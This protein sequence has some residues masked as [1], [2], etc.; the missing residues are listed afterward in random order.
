[1]ERASESGSS[2]A[3]L[4][5]GLSVRMLSGRHGA[6][7]RPTARVAGLAALLGTLAMGLAMALMTGYRTALEERLLEGGASVLVFEVGTLVREGEVSDAEGVERA[8]LSLPGVLAVRRTGFLQGVV[9]GPRGER[10][11]T[12]RLGPPARGAMAREAHRLEPAIGTVPKA[13]LGEE[14]AA[15]LGVGPGARVQLALYLPDS[16]G[17]RF[18]YRSLEVAG[19]YLTGFSEFDTS[20]LVVDPA[21]FPVESATP[22]ARVWEVGVERAES[23]PAV[24]EALREKLGGSWLVTDWTQMNRQLFSALRL[25]Q[26]VLFLLLGLIVLVA[27]FAVGA[28]VAVLGRERR[29]DLALLEALGLERRRI[30]WILGGFA[31]GLTAVGAVSGLGLTYL[32]SELATRFEWLSFGPEVAEVYFLRSVPLRLDLPSAGAILAFTFA[33]ALLASAIPV[34]RLARLDPADALRGD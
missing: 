27:S 22:F 2:V 7:L 14:L 11:V 1:M 18:R 28:T 8:A 4:L 32:I 29:R 30:R 10:E 13:L 33:A 15:A 17:G 9:R 20:W 34:L 16:R 19:T 12:V 5:V 26:R 24:A 23:A 3:A 31:M 25:Q 21:G 6:L